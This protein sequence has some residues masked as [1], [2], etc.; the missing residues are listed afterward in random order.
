MRAVAQDELRRL[1][2]LVL[3]GNRLVAAFAWLDDAEQWVEEFGSPTMRVSEARRGKA[4]A[5]AVGRRSVPAR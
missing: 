4:I 5:P 2:Y 1:N 3:D